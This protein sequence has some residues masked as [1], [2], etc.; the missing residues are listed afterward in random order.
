MKRE[1][2]IHFSFAFAFLIFSALFH[3]WFEPRY[4]LLLLGGVVGTLLPDVDHLIYIWFFGP[5]ELTSQRMFLGLQ[6]RQII[7]T[8]E[9]LA[10]TRS[11]RKKLI[12]HTTFFPVAG[13]VGVTLY[14]LIVTFNSGWV[15]KGVRVKSLL[16]P[17][18]PQVIVGTESRSGKP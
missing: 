6:K 17:Y 12:F 1:F 3:H 2:A 8:L 16:H 4:L 15:G 13:Q 18:L 5:Q 14:N 7:P 11:E 9:L 10:S